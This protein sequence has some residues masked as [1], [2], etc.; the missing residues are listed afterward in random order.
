MVM[1]V[2]PRRSFIPGRKLF[3]VRNVASRLLS[4]VA[5]HPFSGICSNHRGS[6]LPPGG[7]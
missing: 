4:T 7:R 3:R 2:P 1:I 5:R 6:K